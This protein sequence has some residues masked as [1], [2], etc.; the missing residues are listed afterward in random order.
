MLISNTSSNISSSE[1]DTVEE[2]TEL[3][4]PSYKEKVEMTKNYLKKNSKWASM[5]GKHTEEKL[6]LSKITLSYNKIEQ[7]NP[8]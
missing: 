1:N 5:N 4:E 7:K 2:I 8:K 3:N 6:K